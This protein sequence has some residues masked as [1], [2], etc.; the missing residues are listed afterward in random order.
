MP[1]TSVATCP[2]CGSGRTRHVARVQER[3][4]HGCDDCRLTFMDPADRPDPVTER[5]RYE[6]HENDPADPRYRAFL[7]RLREPL[8]ARLAAGAEGLDYGSGPGPALAPMLEEAGF[9]MTIYDPLFAPDPTALKRAYDFITCTETA[10]HFFAPGEEFE[11]LDALLRPGGWLGV[12]TQMRDNAESFERWWYVRD[13]THVCF[14]HP[15]T[16]RWIADRYGWELVGPRPTVW[17]FGKPPS[18][19]RYAPPDQLPGPSRGA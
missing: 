14:Y 1:G 2:L 9:A 11:R 15:A 5:A 3:A 17:L 16:I 12:M 19:A 4:Y 10:E 18:Q 7:D 8:M 13:P 6:T